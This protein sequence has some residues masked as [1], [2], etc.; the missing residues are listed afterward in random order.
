GGGHVL[1]LDAEEAAAV[2]VLDGPVADAAVL[3]LVGPGVRQVHVAQRAVGLADE[4]R[5]A[6]RAPHAFAD[7]GRPLDLALAR[8]HFLSP[9][10]AGPG[11]VVG[12]DQG[13]A[14]GVLAMDRRYL[15]LADKPPLNFSGGLSASSSRL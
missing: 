11:Q 9:R 12:E 13:R 6:A 4:V 15:L 14:A 7:V 3:Q 8:A 10:R 1:G 5:H 2:L